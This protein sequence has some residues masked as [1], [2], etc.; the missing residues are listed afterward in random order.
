MQIRQ[1]ANLKA[2]AERHNGIA[3]YVP[4]PAGTMSGAGAELT[5]WR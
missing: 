2:R 5:E 4:E 3:G 1:L